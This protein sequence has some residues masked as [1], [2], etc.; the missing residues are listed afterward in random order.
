MKTAISLPEDLFREIDDRARQLRL[1][2]SGLIAAAA[3]EF[4]ARHAP[5]NDATEAW[6]RAVARA[7]Q[8]GEEP[9]AVAFRR[10]SK[11]VIRKSGAPR[12][13]HW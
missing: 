8:P 7:G 5:F 10:R 13:R 9:S 2:R 1:S 11:S 3:R 4:L 12:R 6:N